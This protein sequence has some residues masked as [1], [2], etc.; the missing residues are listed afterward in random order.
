MAWIEQRRRADSGRTVYQASCASCHEL[1]GP[2]IGQVTDLADIGTDPERL[3]SFTPELAQKMYRIDE[4]FWARI[5]SLTRKQLDV[6]LGPL[7]DE[8]QIAAILERR[9]RM[10]AEIKSLLK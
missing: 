4:K 10:K 9:D 5:E 2:R 1:G 6:A 7:L 8:R 3:Q